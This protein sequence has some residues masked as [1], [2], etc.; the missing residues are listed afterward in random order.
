[1]ETAISRK[2]RVLIVGAGGFAG[3]W[4]VEEA[5]ARGFEVWAGIRQSTSRKWLSQPEINFLFLDF[6]NPRGLA[7]TLSTALPP[8][9][10]WDY[11]VYN[12]GATKCLRFADFSRINYEYLRDF[13]TAVKAAGMIPRKM[14]YMSSLSVMGPGD[15]K[16]YRPFDEKAIPIP[17]TRYGAS[18]LK[19]EM[20]L[21]T[22]GIPTVIFRPTGLYGPRDHDYFLM[23]ESIDKGFDFSV[24]FRRQMLTFLYAGDLARAVFDALDKAPAGETYCLAENRAYSQK[25][26]RRITA[27]L[28]GKRFVMPVRM[29]LWAVKAVCFLAEKW[30]VA[31]LKPSTLN[32]DK[33]RIMKQR[34]WNVDISKAARDFGF[35]PS[36]SL[37]EGLR[38]SID[39]YRGQEWL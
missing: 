38:R 37:E 27:R 4:L 28:L 6:E 34:N 5:L 15:E 35:S 36:V 32:R 29:P 18:K 1:M 16:G 26:F 30:G 14:L 8:G 12:L 31:R 10:S 13:T 25:E 20:W 21:A 24:G 11:I 22:C 19:A 39:W 2:P 33:Y 3:S 23:I 7:D 17:N 9:E